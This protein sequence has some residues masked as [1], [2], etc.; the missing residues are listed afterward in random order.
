MGESTLLQL[1]D[2]VRFNVDSVKV[3]SVSDAQIDRAIN[4]GYLWATQPTTYEHIE[5]LQRYG[6]FLVAGQ[7]EYDITESGLLAADDRPA[8][9]SDVWYGLSHATY[10]ET[11]AFPIDRSAR[12]VDQEVVYGDQYMENVTITP[13]GEPRRI[14]YFDRTARLDR[15]PRD[16]EAGNILSL[17]FWMQPVLLSGDS[18]KTVVPAIWDYAIEAHATGRILLARGNAER[19]QWWYQEAARDIA[20]TTSMAELRI[21][22]TR[23]RSTI[24]SYPSM[25]PVGGL[26]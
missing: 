20:D 10:H 24:R 15:L 25:G 19:A 11:N 23:N 2:A 12:R 7:D 16:G 4:K 22:N 1:R 18:A 21:A 14:S 26:R 9:T 17:M 5:L 8:V 13:E 6:F 3:A